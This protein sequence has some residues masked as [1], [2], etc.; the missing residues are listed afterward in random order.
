M[1]DRGRNG[2]FAV[3]EEILVDDG[4]DAARGDAT[5]ATTCVLSCV[6][7]TWKRTEKQDGS[8][9]FRPQG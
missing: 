8:N 6:R 7:A 5:T 3:F 4:R 1:K 2:P 9:S